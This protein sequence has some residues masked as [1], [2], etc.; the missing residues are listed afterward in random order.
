MEGITK[1]SGI[2]ASF[3]PSAWN[4]AGL[5]DDPDEI[6]AWLFDPEKRGELYPLCLRRETVRSRTQCAT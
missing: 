6:V 3:A 5:P 2:P 1:A 4:P